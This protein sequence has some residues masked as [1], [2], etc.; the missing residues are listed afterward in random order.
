V[1]VGCA[2]SGAGVPSTGSSE[3]AAGGLGV[4]AA[5]L[6]GAVG[7]ALDAA[8]AALDGAGAAAEVPGAATLTDD[9]HAAVTPA[10]ARP[11]TSIVP[12]C[13]RATGPPEVVAVPLTGPEPSVG[14]RPLRGPVHRAR[15][16]TG[17]HHAAPPGILAG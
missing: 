12:R 11:S 17:P 2:S 4:A 9:V 10:H 8:G 1:A 7:S 16:A 6:D 3:D 14:H 5:V 13:H 15:A